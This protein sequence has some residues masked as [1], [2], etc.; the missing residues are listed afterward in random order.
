MRI[1][2]TGGAGFIGRHL[3]RELAARRY[4][5]VVVD[6]LVDQVH[7]MD[8]AVALP[9]GV[10]FFK[11]DV[12]DM[13]VWEGVLGR[14]DAVVHLAAE[15]GVG[16]SM[17]EIVRYMS[18]NVMGTANMLQVLTDGR[19]SVSKVVVASSMSV[20]GEGSYRCPVC[21]VDVSRA[22]RKVLDL[23][24]CSWEPICPTCASDLVAVATSEESAL[25]PSSVYS[26][27]KR[28]QEELCLSVGRALGIP[29]VALRFFSVYGPGQALSNPYTGVA[30]IFASRLLNEKPP[31]IFEDGNQIR[32]FVHVTDIVQ[33][34]VQ[35]LEGDRADYEAINLGYGRPVT[36]ADVAIGLA[37]AMGSDIAPVIT[38]EYRH[39][40]IRH[41]Y[42]DI[43][44]AR[45]LLGY[46]PGVVFEEGVCDLVE[47][48]KRQT[49]TDRVEFAKQ[50]LDVRGLIGEGYVGSIGG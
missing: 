37:K 17:Y 29:T 7:G 18:T 8:P 26:V 27:S 38:Q 34:L 40:D 14:C 30:A 41:C 33:G 46:K 22:A 48:V 44:K 36:I 42:S 35:A 31:L 19:H 49:A 10:E 43:S 21:S 3:V 9:S 28:D 23:D 50:E 13:K 4:D 1:L 45:R 12:R 47:W 32:D 24:V 5:V 25:V 39:G 15:V 20:Y 2:V 11:A 6:S 16:Q